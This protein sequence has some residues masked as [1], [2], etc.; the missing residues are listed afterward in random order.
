MCVIMASM[1]YELSKLFQLLYLL[2]RSVASGVGWC[3]AP[4]KICQKVH[5]D[6]QYGP[7]MGFCRRVMWVRFKKSTSRVQKVHV[8]RVLHLP[9]ID[10]G[11]RSGIVQIISQPH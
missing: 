5:F 6:K 9:E 8:L 11:Y 1:T 4:P 2:F 7:K 10:P 3:D